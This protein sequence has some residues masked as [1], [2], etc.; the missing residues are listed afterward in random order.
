MAS[1]RPAVVASRPNCAQ[2]VGHDLIYNLFAAPVFTSLLPVFLSSSSRVYPFLSRPKAR[3]DPG[4]M[5]QAFVD[6]YPP[7]SE[8]ALRSLSLRTA[9]TAI[10]MEKSPQSLIAVSVPVGP[11]LRKPKT[12]PKSSN[13]WATMQLDIY[14]LYMLQDLS[15]PDVMK[16]M[17]EEKSF[18]QSY[19]YS[20]YP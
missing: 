9:K 11:P 3:F 5:A 1:I 20:S 14:Q 15:L 16:I 12:K 6:G 17:E 8:G 19:V 7:T 13:E 4:K 18:V 2:T 10:K